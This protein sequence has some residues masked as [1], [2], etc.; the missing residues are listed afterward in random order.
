MGFLKR[1]RTLRRDE[2]GNALAICAA[3]MPLVIGAAGLAIDTVQL[4][5][6]RRELQRSADS[7]ALAGAYAINQNP[8]STGTIRSGYATAGVTRDLELNNNLPM[9]AT[10]VVENAP[11]S[12]TWASNPNAVRVQLQTSRS[13]SFFSFFNAAPKIITAEAT[14]MIVREGEFCMLALE[15]G[16]ATGISAGGNAT[17][18]ITCGMSTNARGPSAI[19]ATGSSSIIASPIMAVG[20]VPTSANFNGAD[21]VPYSAVQQDP[22]GSVPPPTIPAGTPCTPLDVQ[23][24][25]P[26]LS[27]GPGNVCWSGA[28]IKGTV[29]IAPGTTVYVDGGTLSFGSQA[30]VTG[31][32]VAFVLTSSNATSNPASIAELDMNGGAD[33]DITAPGSGPYAGIAFYM[34]RRAP[35]GRTIR[36]NGNSGSTINGAM[37]FPTAYFEYLGNAQMAATCIQLIARRLSFSG[38]GTIRN[39]CSSGGSTQNFAATYVRL[40]S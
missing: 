22:F 36:Y 8:S 15:D 12:G 39:S 3:A 32:D 10:P 23:P 16:N 37:Y 7:G 26:P 27:V 19:T 31:T 38:N 1:L 35:V 28:D 40:V 24:N 29:N 25:D 13:L 17:I 11:T 21:L 6:A 18:D 2:G 30:H 20:G 33:L 4:S 34:D 5:L 14:A 9:S